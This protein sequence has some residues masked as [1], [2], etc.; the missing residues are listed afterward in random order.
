LEYLYWFPHINASLNALSGIFLLFGLAFIK[1]GNAHKHRICML[2]AFT[3]STLFLACYITY[4]S[5]RTYYFGL[6]PTRFTGEGI[7]RPIYF[8]ILGT[9]TILAIVVV[10][11]ILVTLRYALKG[12]FDSHRRLAR[13]TYPMWLY[14]SVTG[15]IV[16][17]MLYQ[18][19]R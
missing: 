19:Y 15:V 8:L 2:S 7:A 1:L 3:T 14:V 17:L 16:Y 5:I 6:G 10:P 4:H 9:H 13:W 11:F 12:R 18:I